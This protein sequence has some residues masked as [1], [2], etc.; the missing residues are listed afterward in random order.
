MVLDGV[1]ELETSGPI[2]RTPGTPGSDKKPT[3]ENSQ[4]ISMKGATLGTSSKSAKYFALRKGTFVCRHH[5]CAP[6]DP[7]K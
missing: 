2:E 6:Q 5:V 4:Q 7:Q 3:I 1:T